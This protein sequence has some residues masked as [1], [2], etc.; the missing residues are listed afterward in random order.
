MATAVYGSYD[1][2]QVWTLRRYRDNK[3]A[4][5]ASGRLFIRSYYAL[6]P[7]LVRL[8]GARSWFRR[9]LKPRLDRLVSRLQ[10]EGVADTPYEDQ[11]K[12]RT[13]STLRSSFPYFASV[14]VGFL[15]ILMPDHMRMIICPGMPRR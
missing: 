15:R 2:P 4:K 6:S 14:S 10:K 7:T 9:L 12:K 5:T 3:L 11:Y 8:F 1:C 13:I